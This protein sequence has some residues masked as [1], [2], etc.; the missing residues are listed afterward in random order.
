MP[1]KEQ[2]HRL[3][4]KLNIPWDNDPSFKSW[5]K[6]VTGKAHLDNMTPE[7]LSRLKK[8][9]AKR[10]AKKKLASAF[11]ES[12]YKEASLLAKALA[13]VKKLKSA[14][15]K[16][17]SFAG[18]LPKDELAVFNIGLASPL[19]G[20]SIAG[21]GAYKGAKEGI[22]ALKDGLPF[23]AYRKLNKAV[24]KSDRINFT[25]K[26]GLLPLYLGMGRH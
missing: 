13:F 14:P 26:G 4:D 2:I 11:S 3:A 8:A 23:S 20:G 5:S 19:P 25:K 6:R 1:S 9:L 21:W 15:K 16:V 10:R 7:E 17:K 12:L 24:A 18:G 22:K